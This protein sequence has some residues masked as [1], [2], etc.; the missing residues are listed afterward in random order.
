M[1]RIYVLALLSTAGRMAVTTRLAFNVSFRGEKV[2]HKALL[3][4]FPM[5]TRDEMLR[6]HLQRHRLK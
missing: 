4:C 2:T 1:F 6:D 3:R 5:D